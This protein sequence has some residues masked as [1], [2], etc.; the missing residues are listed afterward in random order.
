MLCHD[1]IQSNTKSH[2]SQHD[3]FSSILTGLITPSAGTAL[4]NGLDIQV[5]LLLF[6]LLLLVLLPLYLLLLLLL[7]YLLL[8]FYHGPDV[9][10]VMV[11][12][13]PIQG[14]TD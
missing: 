6:L 8:P 4:I 12:W 11:M 9:S 13:P 3:L 10:R 1:I 5:H 7:L 2:I 14:V